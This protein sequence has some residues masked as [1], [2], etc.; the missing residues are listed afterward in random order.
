MFGK[1]ATITD[2]TYSFPPVLK[3]FL[4]KDSSAKSVSSDRIPLITDIPPNE[5]SRQT[6]SST[7]IFSRPYFMFSTP[8]NSEPESFRGLSRSH[9]FLY[10]GISAFCASLFFSLALIFIPLLATPSGL[11]KFVFMYILGNIALMFAFAFAYGPW[12]YIKGL[13]TKDR[14]VSTL[15][16]FS[17]LFLGIYG[18][19]WWR[20]T[21]CALLAIGIQVGLGFW[22]LKQFIWGGTKVLSFMSKFSSLRPG[23]SGS[24]LPV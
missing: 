14:I 16:Y 2:D 17:S 3:S 8:S 5:P 23:G 1:S 21:L 24:T 13:V 22:Q 6:T 12:S 4:N 7:S 10:F 18:V 11:R 20:S 19:F 15:V 9:R